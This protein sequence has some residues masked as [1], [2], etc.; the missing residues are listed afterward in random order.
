MDNDN[1]NDDN[2]D[3]DVDVD[4]PQTQAMEDVKDVKDEYG[5][6]WWRLRKKLESVESDE[7]A[8]LTSLWWWRA[9]ASDAICFDERMSRNTAAWDEST[10]FRSIVISSR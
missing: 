9:T 1:D 2:D 6:C 10:V 7:Y 5:M 4:D 8:N 3:D